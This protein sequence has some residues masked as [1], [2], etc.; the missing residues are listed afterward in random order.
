M[1]F[2]LIFILPFVGAL[3]LLVVIHEFGHFA[4][5]RAMGVKVLEFG[6]GFPPR[7]FGF[8]TGKTLVMV[9]SATRFVNIDGVAGLRTGQL[10]KVSSAEDQDGNL[11]ARVVEAP[12]PRRGWASRLPGRGGEGEKEESVPV[13]YLKHEGKVRAVESGHFV[14][15]DML[16]SVNWAP[17]GGFVRLA[18]ESDPRVPRSLASK[19]VATRFLVLVAG[20]FMNA[21][22]PIVVFTVLFMI[23]QDVVVGQVVVSRITAGTPAEEAGLL[24]GDIIL[25][26]G[27][28]L[29]ENQNDLRRATNLNGN[30]NMEWLV[31]RDGREVVV[32]VHPRF[33]QPKGQW[34][35]GILISEIAGQVTVSQVFDGT[36]AEEAGLQPD[37]V[38]AEAGGRGITNTGD[39]I[40]AIAFNEDAA[41]PWV[42]I[43]EGR[44]QPITVT[45]RFEQERSRQWITG[46]S[47]VLIDSHAE[48]RSEPPWTAVASGF[49]STWELLVM[50]KQALAGA[51]DA[52]EVPELSGPIGIA[53][54]T[55]EITRDGGLTGWLVI[56]VL[57]S[58]NLAILNILPLPMLDGGRLVFVMLEWVRRGKRVPPE[59]EGLVHL[60][61]FVVLIGA[62]LVI[63]ANDINRLI[64]G[65]S[66]L[67][68]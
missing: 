49:A 63:S 15:A 17:L 24:P 43:R 28:R 33:E 68:G 19:G 4:T 67:G 9:D 44:Q 57:L 65:N 39:L 16:Y 58:I 25:Q 61:G 66:F 64:Q 56:T 47:T 59:K 38:I 7:A 21:I 14:L 8:Y 55:G 31:V 52:G 42:I 41:M 51:F 22:F 48:S 60:I 2:I 6:V 32:L 34:R 30:S 5:A 46:E 29:I 10:V 37:D 62:V 35:A 13:E 1:E 54:V 40:E 53:Q 50:I 26:A 18:G 36:P 3:L 11:V 27:G 23:P 12:K 20:P 45:P